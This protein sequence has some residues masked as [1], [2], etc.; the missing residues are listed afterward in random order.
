MRL[1]VLLSLVTGCQLVFPLEG[2]RDPVTLRKTYLHDPGTTKRI[3]L[4]LDPAVQLGD[5]LIVMIGARELDDIEIEEL[6]PGWTL[7]AEEEAVMCPGQFHVSFLKTVVTP[8]TESESE[9]DFDVEG[10]MNVLVSV[11]TGASDARLLDFKLMGNLQNEPALAFPEATLAPGSIAWF[12]GS[13][14]TP[15]SDIDA[16]VGTER[17][18]AVA[19]LAAFQLPVRDGQLP[20]VVL[21]NQR[22]LNEFCANVA[23][24]SVEP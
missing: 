1:T 13:A 17:I 2:D 11:Y 12:G 20:E 19:Q 21:P 5:L 14:L 3:T 10:S 24:I 23:Q 15:W 22:P 6:S 8:D 4:P 9:I 16:P 7:M 18:G